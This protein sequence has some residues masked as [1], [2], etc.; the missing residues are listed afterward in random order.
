MYK[1]HAETAAAIGESIT[2]KTLTIDYL[3]ERLGW[4]PDFVK[5]DVEGAEALVLEGAHNLAAKKK[6]TFMI[7]MHSPPELPMVEN[8]SLVLKWANESGYSVWYMKDQKVLL[9]AKDIAHRG[10]CH[11]L[12]MPNGRTYPSFLKD[13]SQGEQLPAIR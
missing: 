13:I 9:E 6:T 7:E 4:L 3:V 11:L 5:I 12:L 10:K 8:A 1:G 2:V